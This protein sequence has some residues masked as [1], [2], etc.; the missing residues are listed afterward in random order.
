MHARASYLANVGAGGGVDER[1]GGRG[2]EDLHVE[3][4]LLIERV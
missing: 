4:Q 1:D 3:Q 2:A